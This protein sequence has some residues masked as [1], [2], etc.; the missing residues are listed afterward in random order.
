MTDVEGC[1][2]N[3]QL[4][5]SIGNSVG[6]ILMGLRSQLWVALVTDSMGKSLGLM[7]NI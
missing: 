7:A 4:N 1:S 6:Q 3:E 2:A 5:G